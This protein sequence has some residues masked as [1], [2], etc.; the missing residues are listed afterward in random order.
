[1][2]WYPLLNYVK[3]SYLFDKFVIEFVAVKS[4]QLGGNADTFMSIFSADTLD[5]LVTDIFLEKEIIHFFR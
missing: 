3:N 5:F 1:M 4:A 2:G